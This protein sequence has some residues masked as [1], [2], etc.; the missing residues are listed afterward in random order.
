MERIWLGRPA[1][2]AA[3]SLVKAGYTVR[4][5]PYAGRRE[6]PGAEDAR[7]MRCRIEGNTAELTVCKFVTDVMRDVE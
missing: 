2:E 1:N 3:H 7:V 6:Q 5:V 4:M